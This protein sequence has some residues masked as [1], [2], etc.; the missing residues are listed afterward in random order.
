MD[1]GRPRPQN[2]ASRGFALSAD[3]N[4]AKRKDA[5]EAA[6]GPERRRKPQVSARP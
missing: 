4:N 2:G 5:R 3:Q 1:R 6:R